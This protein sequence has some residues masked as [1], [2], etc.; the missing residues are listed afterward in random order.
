MSTTTVLANLTLVDGSR[1]R[2]I[3]K[4]NLSSLKNRKSDLDLEN[5]PSPTQPTLYP[6]REVP[7]TKSRRRGGQEQQKGLQSI[8][9]AEMSRLVLAAY[10]WDHWL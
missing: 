5:F 8:R 2:E 3:E 9:I 6:E 10:V 7:G 1:N 4:S